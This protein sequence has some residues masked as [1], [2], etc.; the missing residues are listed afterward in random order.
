MCWSMKSSFLFSCLG[1]VMTLDQ[2][3][4]FLQLVPSKSQ[5]SN[6]YKFKKAALFSQILLYLTYFLMES[7]QFTQYYFGL[8]D[9]CHTQSNKILTIMAHVLIWGQPLAQNYWCLKNTLK[10]KTLYRFTLVASFLCLIVSSISLY[11]G[12]NGMM[13]HPEATNI[14][15]Q[16]SSSS[17]LEITSDAYGTESQVNHVPLQNIGTSLCSYQGPN[18][19]YWMF[20]Y[21]QLYGYAPH[22]FTWLLITVL[23]HFFRYQ[24]VD[25]WFMSNYI[26]GFGIFSGWVLSV[27]ISL[28]FGVFH[29]IW[30]YWCLESVPYLV[31]PYLYRIIWRGIIGGPDPKHGAANELL[32]KEKLQ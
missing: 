8:T 27:I 12:Y 32:Q 19:L 3:R 7:L 1:L 21:H 6:M 23:P 2:V 25:D 22:W 24:P 13:G 16:A 26:M 9:S 29:E 15:A 10:G 5:S 18:H 20:P 28:N 11:L 31:L 14:S 4:R 17:K 30:S